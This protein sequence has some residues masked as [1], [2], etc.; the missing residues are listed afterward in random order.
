MKVLPIFIRQ[1]YA[2][3]SNLL[4]FSL[5]IQSE[6]TSRNYIPSRR[7]AHSHSTIPT[8]FFC[9]LS[10]LFLTHPYRL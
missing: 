1:P 7:I 6:F 4:S 3:V 5:N 10:F 8:V 2:I 9:S